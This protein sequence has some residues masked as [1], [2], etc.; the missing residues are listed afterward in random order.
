VH[1]GYLADEVCG[2]GCGYGVASILLAKAFPKARLWGY[3]A[4]APSIEKARA[5]AAKAGVEGRVTFE[6]VDAVRMPARRFDLITS[7]DVLHDSA[8]PV[9]IV[10]S[11][12]QALASGGAYL[13]YEPDLSP[14][15]EENMNL[16]GR[17]G[18]PIMTMYCMTVSLAQ[19][20]AGV[21]PDMNEGLLRQWAAKTGFGRVRRLPLASP[22][23]GLYELRA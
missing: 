13:V 22:A 2:V 9:G 5:N 6:V 17:F 4:H 12:R 15:L 11:V 1:I 8:D 7:F 19:G 14:N 10:G 3:D 23:M 18:Y 20:G 21:G 16:G